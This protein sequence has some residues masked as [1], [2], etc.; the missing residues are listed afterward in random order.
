MKFTISDKNKLLI[1]SKN[2]D[3]NNNIRLY[4]TCYFLFSEQNQLKKIKLEICN[5]KSRVDRY[6]MRVVQLEDFTKCQE[7]VLNDITCKLYA[8]R[9]KLK[10]IIKTRIKQLV[11]YIFTLDEVGNSNIIQ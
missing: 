11:I 4:N 9:P 2:F 10:N 8:N 1:D 3:I 7:T 5:Q 6:A